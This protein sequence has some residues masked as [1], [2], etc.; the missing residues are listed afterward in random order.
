L[1]LKLLTDILSRYNP[2]YYFAIETSY[3]KTY[4]L[5]EMIDEMHKNGIR[6]ILDG[7]RKYI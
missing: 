5:K 6:V 2:R 7:V 3:G 1:F 4:D